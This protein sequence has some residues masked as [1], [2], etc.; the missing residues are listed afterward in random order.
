MNNP[1]HRGVAQIQ[2]REHEENA[3]AKRVVE[4]LSPGG[5]IPENA[6]G[7]TVTGD[8]AINGGFVESGGNQ[9]GANGSLS[10]TIA[11][12]SDE[13]VLCARPVARSTGVDIEGALSWRELV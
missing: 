13:I 5:S 4:V 1:V 12:V 11:G 6:S 7:K 2:Q 3:S 8:F 10:S 9:A